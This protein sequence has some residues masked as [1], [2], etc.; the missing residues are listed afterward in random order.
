VAGPSASEPKD[1]TGS[2][3]E[4]NTAAAGEL[5]FDDAEDF[6]DAR[7]GFV[8]GPA[9]PVIRDDA[10]NTVWDMS[11]YGFLDESGDGAGLADAPP[12]VHP[13]LW[14]QARLNAMA[15]LYEVAD[16][17]YQVRGY[18]ISNMALI[19]GERGVIVVDP[20]ISAECAA[21]ALD[22]YR[23]H[24]GE[25]PVSALLYTHNHVDHW[26]GAK[27]VVDQ[28]RVRAGALPVWAPEGFLEHA[29][30]ENV[31]AGTAMARRSAYMF[32]SFLPRG[33]RG[34]VDSGVGKATSEGSV[35][36]I[37]PTHEVTVTGQRETIDGVNFVFQLTPETEAPA[38]LNFQ[39]PQRSA[40]CVAENATHTLHNLLTLRGAP[41][42][43]AL[44]WS[45]YLNESIE[46]FA[47][48]T[49]VLFHGHH[50]PRWGRER[51]GELLARHRDLY[52]YLHDQTLRLMNAGLTG[53]EIAA[54]IELPPS[55]A[56]SWSCRGLYGTVSHNVRAVYQR[57]LGYFDGNPA[58]LDPLPP[59][60]AGR[61]YVALAGGG[62][63]AL[64]H[65]R[66]AFERG[67]YR[68]AA[69]LASHL[70]FADPG[71]R[72]AR[73]LEADALEQLG[74]RSESAIWRNY[75][76]A[77][78]FELR[79]GAQGS[80]DTEGAARDVAR[81]LPLELL[82]DAMGARLNGP[83]ATGKRIVVNWRF[84]DL[85]EEWAMTVENAALS[86]V[87][88]RH[89]DDADAMIA[90]TREA[91]DS[92]VLEGPEAA[93]KIAPGD[94]EVT[95]DGE[96]LGELLGLFDPPDPRFE[97]VAP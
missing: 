89:A 60:E 78:A 18:D 16:G 6:A 64:N 51:I 69:Q 86:T 42:R 20:L 59:E 71:D 5:P 17:V 32:G 22:L 9:D 94:L 11:S 83:R 54:A 67:E 15:G 52:R 3:R 36:L 27:G 13:A 62:D 53:T 87:R 4:A 8:A 61:R 55:L 2:T 88:G 48:S 74:Y 70:V 46:L 47:P 65:A 85:D 41:V 31:L 26:G 72:E 38:E 75:Y 40:L 66:Q 23:S 63:G 33:E 93:A 49:E 39:L 43:D 50:W 14:R 25:R 92:L 77:G 84:T 45:K 24:R 29:V 97:V 73:E 19:E 76:L 96:K 10:G 7:R 80:R 28:D 37:P 90:L 79:E 91:L 82:F 34:Q 35:T 95:G 44:R 21:A 30:S 1:A 58:H 68:W 57:Y 12:T 56:R 81:A